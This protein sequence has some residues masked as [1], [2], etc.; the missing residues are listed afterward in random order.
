MLAERVVGDA[1]PRALGLPTASGKTACIDI[2]IYALA[3]Q[4]ELLPFSRTA[5]R[6]IWFVVDRRIVVDEAY[7]RATTIA[8]K[9]RA[10]RDGPLAAV[11]SRL[12]R[13]AVTGRPLAV[14]R[15]RGGIIRDDSWA[16]VPSQPAVITS[17]VDQVGSR[18][19]FRAYGPGE[20]TASI[21]A[22]LAANDSLLV[23]DEAHCSV[24]LLQTIRAVE[25][26]RGKRWATSPLGTPFAFV[27]LSAT[28]PAE[29]P[30]DAV[31]PGRD[32]EQA[33]DHPVLEKRLRTPK[34]AELVE[35]KVKRAPDEDPLVTEATKRALLYL[36]AG[37]RRVVVMVNRVRTAE[38]VAHEL[39]N[40]VRD[41]TADVVLLT[42][43]LRPYERD[44][45]VER[46]KP[47][48]R[49]ASPEEPARPI[50]LVSTQ[51]LEVGADFSFEALVSEAAS[52]DAL[53]QRFGRL[54][55]MGAEEPAT[56][57][58]L[59]RDRD[60]DPD[61]PDPVY[62][63]A[64]P[65]TWR[66]LHETAVQ[67]TDGK[68]TK[69][70]VDLGVD[71]LDRSLTGL[72][73]L[74]PYLAPTAEAP[75]LLPAHID[76]LCQ[77]AP[78]A[79]PEPDVQVFLH[80][81][82]R[83]APEAQVVWRAD[84]P[85]GSEDAW[86]ET[87]ALCRPT[88]GEMLSAPLYRV[89]VWLSQP[90]S[91]DDSTDI[92]G[93]GAEDGH[94]SRASR[95]FLLWRGPDR[96]RITREPG[97]IAPG[98][99]IVVPAAYGID[100]LGQSAPAEA[101][102]GDELD[103]WEPA[104]ASSGRPPAARVQREALEPWIGCPPLREL[105]ELCEGPSVSRNDLDDAIGQVLEYF[106]AD[107]DEPTPPPLWWLELLGKARKGR[108]ESHPSGGLIL[109]AHDA[110]RASR[111]AEPDLL[112]DEADLTSEAGSPVTLDEHTELV[113]RTV[114]KLAQ[115]CLPEELAESMHL[116]ARWHDV[117]KLDERF[118]LLLHHGNEI[119]AASADSALAKSPSVPLSPAR[120]RAIR[121][122][123]GLPRQF[124]HEMVSAALFERYAPPPED[125][126][127][128]DLALHLIA[129]HH[130]HARPFC[131]VV[132]DPDPPPIAGH[133]AGSVIDV[134]GDERAGW[135]PLHRFDS[136]L[137]ERFWRLSRRY[138]W[139]GLAYLEAI[140]RLGDW[141]ASS[142][143]EGRQEGAR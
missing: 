115:L 93:V 25:T 108:F 18:L 136:G 60:M 53:R 55:R 33:L 1:W 112:E 7:D 9:L 40:G 56:A 90:G 70:V 50:V 72:D 76:L 39:R 38:R 16:R 22:G 73:D 125:P 29:I 140:F 66:L 86:I 83:G 62:G 49:A 91:P 107:E 111:P 26:Y 133:F 65:E 48:L 34:P 113:E 11:A 126:G 143:V 101:L 89:V 30:K 41:D 59:A 13:L 68:T 47:Y 84:L 119:A 5:P 137:A 35:V 97:E 132:D 117:G 36:E 96:S 130:G 54:A 17:T 124:R 78:A 105:V 67:E 52:L 116:A 15:L 94:S 6:R 99:V 98:D 79:H 142:L 19:L 69:A 8:E 88:V 118:Q 80:G 85:P 44:R 45:L 114:E 121:D 46:W 21:Y 64:L 28:P 77:T 95:P 32:R 74:S 24:P 120:R 61:S 82:D 43:R 109:I 42:G 138:G 100:G 23:L 81:K 63:L 37:K 135:Q 131:P 92:E 31:F 102:G 27:I 110:D 14:A 58:V 20:L 103:L 87:V 2:G 4:A 106:P 141:Y 10:A 139:W 134:N 127:T 75:V 57:T 71:A 51:C 129:S 3:H 122:A 128:A 123:T 104:W 12:R